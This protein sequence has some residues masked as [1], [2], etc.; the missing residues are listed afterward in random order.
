VVAPGR[1]T[2]SAAL[3]AAGRPALEMVAAALPLFVVAAL[4][5]SFVRQSTLSSPARFV[6]AAIALGSIAGYGLYVYRLARRPTPQDLTW[7]LK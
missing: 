7:L 2:V 5:E 3:R 4:V 1:Q 6:A